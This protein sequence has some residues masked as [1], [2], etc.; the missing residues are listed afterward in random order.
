LL[1]MLSITWATAQP[2]FA[3]VFFMDKVLCFG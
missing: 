1:E 2:F 3:F